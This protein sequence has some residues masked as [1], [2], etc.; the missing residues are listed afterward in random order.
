MFRLLGFFRLLVALGFRVYRVLAFGFRVLALGF[1][2]LAL[3][4]RV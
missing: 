1:R 4:L 3:G 2:V